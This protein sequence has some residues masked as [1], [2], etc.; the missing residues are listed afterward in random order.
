MIRR[1]TRAI[2]R[3]FQHIFDLLQTMCGFC[4]LRKNYIV[5]RWPGDRPLAG[6]RRIA[7]FVHYDRR[8]RVHDYVVHYL[9]EL[10]QAGFEIIFVSNSPSAFRG[11]LPKIQSL[12]CLVLQRKNIGYDFG[13]YKDA[14]FVIPDLAQL[15]ALIFAND[16]AY[17]PFS[18]LA[19][20]LAQCDDAAAIWGI[21]DSWDRRFH[22]QSY[23]MLWKKE[24]LTDPRMIDFWRKVRYFQSKRVVVRKYE[25]R[26][27]QQA[28]RGG[29]R[30]TALFPQR[31]VVEALSSAVLNDNL[32][33]R[34]GISD[35]HRAFLRRVY[36][37]IDHG[38]PVNITHFFWD[39]LISDLGCP[40]LKR[41]LLASNPMH[42][43]FL[44]Q[45]RN[46]IERTTNYDTDLIARHLEAT[47]RDRA[48]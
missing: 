46:I 29:L 40:F 35:Q 1:I 17:G 37:A 39:Y 13:A 6:A 21:T 10:L 32:L 25:V 42:V 5:R 47:I 15:D 7:I 31:R 27:T 28:I 36:D 26:L 34:E 14:L 22:L 30:C 11:S 41:E 48:I 20:L 43:P 8:G 44:S 16:S 2:I 3:L 4:R 45:W 24:A 38:L 9:N 18:D 33:E 12:C 19:A 23:F